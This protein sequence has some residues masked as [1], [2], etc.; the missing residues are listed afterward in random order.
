MNQ[1]IRPVLCSHLNDP[2]IREAAVLVYESFSEFYDQLGLSSRQLLDLIAAQM[3]D[4]EGTELEGTMATLDAA[5]RV[6]GILAAYPAAELQQR[7][8]GSIFNLLAGLDEGHTS[9]ALSAI[10]A[11]TA[12]APELPAMSF[13]VARFAVSLA[14]RG[15]SIAGQLMEVLKELAKDYETISLHSLASNDRAIAFYI[16]H[17]FVFADQSGHPYRLL[18]NQVDAD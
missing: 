16:K 12:Q 10:S 5:D 3:A 15:T 2:A 9:T 1:T 17:G 14:S 7:Q 8:I 4:P 11:Y 6:T 13:Y 18:I